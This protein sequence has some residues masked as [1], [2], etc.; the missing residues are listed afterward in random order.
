M[1]FPSFQARAGSDKLPRF[2]PDLVEG[3]QI[4]VAWQIV[5][6]VAKVARRRFEG[7]TKLTQAELFCRL[8]PP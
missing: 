5:G 8:R 2:Y 3:Q 7:P 6:M 1:V 4:K